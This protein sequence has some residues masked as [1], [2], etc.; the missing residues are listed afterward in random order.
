MSNC[1][2]DSTSKDPPLA[3]GSKRVKS[4]ADLE[5]VKQLILFFLLV[6]APVPT[7]TKLYFWHSNHNLTKL[8]TFVFQIA[9]KFNGLPN[10]R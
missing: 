9:S 7:T 3:D 6:S 5:M 1:C 2:I 4:S 8:L 10:S